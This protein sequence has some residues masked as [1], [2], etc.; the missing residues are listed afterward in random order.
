MKIKLT[1]F[2]N[3]KENLAIH[4]NTKEKANE[5]LKAFDKLGKK[6]SN[7][8]SYLDVDY[9]TLDYGLYYRNTC[10]SNHNKF[11]GYSNYKSHDYTIY[12]FEDVDLDK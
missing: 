8:M 10:Y 9:Y 5:L 11:N 2:W 4:C 1:E 7:G 12:E 3:S 6:W